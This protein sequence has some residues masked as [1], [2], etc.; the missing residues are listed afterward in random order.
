MTLFFRR[1]LF[2]PTLA[3]ANAATTANGNRFKLSFNSVMSAAN[4]I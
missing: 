1:L 3:L 4:D 2:T